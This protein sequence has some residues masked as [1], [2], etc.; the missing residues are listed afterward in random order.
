MCTV[1]IDCCFALLVALRGP[2]NSKYSIP[3]R[4]DT[5]D[6]KWRQRSTQAK[7]GQKVDDSI[8][9]TAD[10][11][12]QHHPSDAVDDSLSRPLLILKLL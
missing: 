10:G 12:I 8:L 9:G 11:Q 5:S 7:T 4:K 3:A 6:W 2:Q 1:K